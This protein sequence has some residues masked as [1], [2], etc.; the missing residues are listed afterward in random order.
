MI[1]RTPL[2]LRGLASGRKLLW[3]LYKVHKKFD[4]ETDEKRVSFLA[5]MLFSVADYC[6][7]SA[8]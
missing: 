3:L 2:R 6:T 5:G 8:L 1:R 4:R 7:S